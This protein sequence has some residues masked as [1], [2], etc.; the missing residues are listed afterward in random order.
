L[1]K[2]AVNEF[3]EKKKLPS[4][5]NKPIISHYRG[6]LI[7]INSL[8]TPHFSPVEIGKI[9]SV[10]IDVRVIRR[11]D[12][13]YIGKTSNFISSVKDSFPGEARGRFDYRIYASSIKILIEPPNYRE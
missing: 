4:Y 5:A 9:Y 10:N 12:I 6:N 1:P 8:F 2:D 11:L 7:E 3:F 13:S